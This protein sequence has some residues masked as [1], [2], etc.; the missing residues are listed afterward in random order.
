MCSSRPPPARRGRTAPCRKRRKRASRRWRRTA[1][2]A[3]SSGGARTNLQG[4][5]GPVVD[6][7][8]DLPEALVHSQIPPLAQEPLCGTDGYRKRSER[9]GG[10]GRSAPSKG[11]DPKLEA[12]DEKKR[13]R[14]MHLSAARFRRQPPGQTRLLRFHVGFRPYAHLASASAG[15]LKH[16]GPPQGVRRPSKRGGAEWVLRQFVDV[17][18]M[19][20]Q[21]RAKKGE[22]RR[23]TRVR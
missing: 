13:V 22:G 7:W 6:G 20:T 5:P 9:G 11:E 18:Q 1:T 21:T 10:C 16:L 8:L 3:E 15:T 2:R 4:A 23:A 14:A 19:R 17:R 12:G